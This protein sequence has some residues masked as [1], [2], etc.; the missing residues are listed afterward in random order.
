MWVPNIFKSLTS[1][2]SRRRPTRRRPSSARLS[3]E[4]LEDRCVPSYSVIGLGT[5]GGSYS[6]VADINVPARSSGG[7]PLP[8]DRRTPSSGRTAS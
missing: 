7:R 2:P 4:A 1:S 5:L 3:L 8:L 6:Y